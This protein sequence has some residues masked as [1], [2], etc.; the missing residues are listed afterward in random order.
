M[1]KCKRRHLSVDEQKILE[2]LHVR[3]LITPKDRTR[4]DELILE[5][6]YLHDATLVGEQLRYV[7]TYKGQW[8][9]LATWSGAAFHL[10]DRDQFIGWDFPAYPVG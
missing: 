3:L 9:A 7:A 10:K 5:H 4:C 1:A 2:Q 8:L 6:H